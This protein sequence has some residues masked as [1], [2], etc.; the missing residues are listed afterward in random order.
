MLPHEVGRVASEET[1]FTGARGT[2]HHDA[3]AQEQQEDEKPEQQSD[4]A[5]QSGSDEAQEPSWGGERQRRGPLRS[6]PVSAAKD[7]S[8]PLKRKRTPSRR[9]VEAAES[10]LLLEQLIAQETSFAARIQSH[11]GIPTREPATDDISWARASHP[12]W[13][14]A[15]VFGAVEP[16]DLLGFGVPLGDVLHSENEQLRRQ[17]QKQQR[18]EVS[19]PAEEIQQR[20]EPQPHQQE[21]QQQQ[22]QQQ[23]RAARGEPAFVVDVAVVGAGVAGLAAAAYLRRCGA[24]VMVFEGRHRVGGRTFSSVMPER[25]LPDGRKIGQVVIDLGASYMHCVTAKPKAEE[26]AA[27]DCRWRREPSRSVSGIAAV[28]KPLVADVAG[29]QNWESTLFASWFD[30]ASGRELPFL[31][32]LKVHELLDRLRER[33]AAKLLHLPP[34]LTASGGPGPPSASLSNIIPAAEFLS[35]SL[36]QILRAALIRQRGG[37]RRGD[38]GEGGA[39]S[40]VGD[41][42]EALAAI[43]FLTKSKGRG[44]EYSNTPEVIASPSAASRRA[45]SGVDEASENVS[46]ALLQHDTS[47]PCCSR[48]SSASRKN[49]CQSLQRGIS[50]CRFEHYYPLGNTFVR[51][52]IRAFGGCPICCTGTCG[53]ANRIVEGKQIPAAGVDEQGD[54]SHCA[55]RLLFWGEPAPLFVFQEGGKKADAAQFESHTVDGSALQL[56]LTHPTGASSDA[57]DLNTCGGSARREDVMAAEGTLDGNKGSSEEA[58]VR[59]Q[60]SLRKE[61]KR[62]Q[63]RRC[64]RTGGSTCSRSNNGAREPALKC[65]RLRKSSTAGAQAETRLVPQLSLHDNEGI[66]RSAWEALEISLCELLAEA[67]ADEG[68]LSLGVGCKEGT[69]DCRPQKPRRFSLL[70]P[71]EA[72]MLLVV[73]QSRLGYVGDLRELPVSAVKNYPYEVAAVGSALRRQLLTPQTRAPP[74]PLVVPLPSSLQRLRMQQ[75]AMDPVLQQEQRAHVHPFCASAASSAD[76]LVVDGWGWLPLFLCL[77]VIPFVVTDAIVQSIHIK[78]AGSWGLTCIPGVSVAGKDETFDDGSLAC[79]DDEDEEAE[80]LSKSH[81][82]RLLVEVNRR[83][84]YRASHGLPQAAEQQERPAHVWVHAKYCIVAV[85]LAQLALAPLPSSN[86]VFDSAETPSKSM[87]PPTLGLIDFSP[88]LGADRRRALARYRMGC[89]NKV[90][91]EVLGLL[92]Q[93]FDI[94]D[95]Y[96][97]RPVDFIVSRWEEDCFSRGSYSTPGVNAYDNDLDV[98]RAPHP[99]Q[100]PRVLFCGEH[101]SKAYFQCVDGAFD[102]G[103]RAGEAVAHECLQLPLPPR[104]DSRRFALD[105]FCLP[106]GS[107]GRKRVSFVS[108]VPSRHKQLQKAVP[109]KPVSFER[110]KEDYGATVSAREEP[111]GSPMHGFLPQCPFSGFPLPPLPRVLRGHYLTDQSDLGLT[112]AEGGDWAG[113]GTG[114]RGPQDCESERRAQQVATSEEYFLACCLLYIKKC[115]AQIFQCVE[116]QHQQQGCGRLTMH[117]DVL[118]ERAIFTGEK[119]PCSSRSA[120]HSAGVGECACGGALPPSLSVPELSESAS[121]FQSQLPTAAQRLFY[122]AFLSQ[123]PLRQQSQSPEFCEQQQDSG[124][125]PEHEVQ[126]NSTQGQVECEE[127]QQLPL[128]KDLLDAILMCTNSFDTGSCSAQPSEASLLLHQTFTRRMRRGGGSKVLDIEGFLVLLARN[129]KIVR[130]SV[131]LPI[132]LLAES[133]F[134][135][136]EEEQGVLGVE[137]HE[138]PSTSESA[139]LERFVKELM[140]PALPAHARNAKPP[141][142]AAV[143]AGVVLME[144]LERLCAAV[145]PLAAGETVQERAAALDALV[146]KS[147]AS[148]QFVSATTSHGASQGPGGRQGEDADAHESLQHEQ[149]CWLCRGEG[150]LLLCDGL[151]PA[152]SIN[153]TTAENDSTASGTNDFV[154]TCRP[155]CHVFHMGCAFPPPTPA[156]LQPNACWSCPLCKATAF[157]ERRGLQMRQQEFGQQKQ[158]QT[159]DQ[160]PTRRLARQVQYDRQHLSQHDQ[161]QQQEGEGESMK[162]ASGADEAGEAE[163]LFVHHVLTSLHRLSQQEPGERAVQ[164]LRLRLA[165]CEELQLAALKR[166]FVD[167]ARGILACTRQLCKRLE[168]L[169]SK[170]RRLLAAAKRRRWRLRARADSSDAQNQVSG[171]SNSKKRS[172]P[173]QQQEHVM[174]PGNPL[175]F[176]LEEKTDASSRSAMPS[177]TAALCA[178]RRRSSFAPGRSVRADD[179]EGDG[180]LEANKEQPTRRTRRSVLVKNSAHVGAVAGKPRSPGRNLADA[181]V[182]AVAAGCTSAREDRAEEGE[183]G[184]S[185]TSPDEDSSGSESDGRFDQF[186]AAARTPNFAKAIRLLARIREADGTALPLKLSALQHLQHL[187]EGCL[188]R[189]QRAPAASGAQEDAARFALLNE[190]GCTARRGS[191]NELCCCS[192]QGSAGAV[193][194]LC[195]RSMKRAAVDALLNLLEFHEESKMPEACRRPSFRCLVPQICFSGAEIDGLSRGDPFWPNRVARPFR[196]RRPLQPRLVFRDACDS[197]STQARRQQVALLA[198]Q[199]WQLQ[200]KQSQPRLSQHSQK[201][202]QELRPFDEACARPVAPNAGLLLSSLFQP[203][204]PVHGQRW[205]PV[206]DSV[207]QAQMNTYGDSMRSL[208]QLLQGAQRQQQRRL[209]EAGILEALQMQHL[210]L[211]QVQQQLLQQ[212][213]RCT[214]ALRAAQR[215]RVETASVVGAPRGRLNSLDP[216]MK[217][218]APEIGPQMSPRPLSVH[219]QAAYQMQ[220]SGIYSQAL[221]HQQQVQERRVGQQQQQQLAPAS[222]LEGSASV[223]QQEQDKDEV[224]CLLQ[225]AQQDSGVQQQLKQRVYRLQQLQRHLLQLQRQ[226]RQGSTPHESRPQL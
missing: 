104:E 195:M 212:Q 165:A 80:A 111:H 219:G 147:L 30:E 58:L 193:E 3:Q 1:P 82:V 138:D 116:V 164:Q 217:Y 181:E 123:Y 157:R 207:L 48:A 98:M 163:G 176:A 126:P 196:K 106:P 151:P 49:N 112:D 218:T 14:A 43:S 76:K 168:F 40:A 110:E 64:S 77:Q 45:C 51:K 117:V 35:P 91:A 128:L 120:A 42:D 73:L 39:R 201:L 55:R 124:T 113:V 34:P 74:V 6:S 142:M 27:N 2:M 46:L 22:Q 153:N 62:Q 175:S 135:C 86:L 26:K 84:E 170:R 38:G 186:A 208:W 203:R 119:C 190:K 129:N 191:I 141:R 21:Q 71:A 44:E 101:L 12:Q 103:L 216:G 226:Q 137:P 156:E 189:L 78:K 150:D 29:K 122:R 85:P 41:S 223:Q 145:P 143:A 88:P 4:A 221:H 224:F 13:P 185:Q 97:P 81:P 31:S 11:G 63:S 95:A 5:P 108:S 194:C 47:D 127:Q 131:L 187:T 99:P 211:L 54:A 214:E 100:D 70:S 209:P 121:S 8:A 172:C 36:D 213:Q 59:V 79:T 154:S 167:K 57:G 183:A 202:T 107:G 188:C 136:A 7:A 200:H 139:S 215:A 15:A 67:E 17:W 61:C 33:T 83:L 16:R 174:S 152:S 87:V 155:C 206:A 178:P 134:R 10:A 179:E 32:V 18:Q 109:V 69:K 182:A 169:S 118:P 50:P 159:E 184:T 180:Q 177:S 146:L 23:Q 68:G 192:A 173:L 20:Q 96:F 105:F 225:R 90:V 144:S 28:L 158:A 132:R 204:S 199:L 65:N 198:A 149:L 94:P 133:S 92:Q 160:Q 210:Q 93:M 24:T 148:S 72:R 114:R 102:T 140:L 115:S 60:P 220:P 166:L 53:G 52:A 162:Q 56:G 37:E 130:D 75:T 171:T 25:Q 9:V 66:R 161:S 19:Q 89:H 125:S 205:P 197:G 222:G